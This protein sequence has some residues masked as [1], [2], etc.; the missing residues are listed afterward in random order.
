MEESTR[1]ELSRATTGLTA[2]EYLA[3]NINNIDTD[4]D[5][6]I[7][8]LIEADSNAQFIVSAAR[9]LSSIDSSKFA[10]NID[11]LVKAAI[12]IDREHK[13]IGQLLSGIW[14]EDYANQATE[15]YKSDDNFRRI[16]KRI[17]EK[18]SI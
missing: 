7:T 12:N 17:Y 10:K 8:L 18:N 15:L 4:I 16:Y 1:K 6:V 11:V 14:G 5:E 9:Y 2:Y 3:N 13:Y